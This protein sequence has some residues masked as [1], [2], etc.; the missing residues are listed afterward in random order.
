M[1]RKEEDFSLDDSRDIYEV[2]IDVISVLI[3]CI[4]ILPSA[5]TTDFVVCYA[6]SLNLSPTFG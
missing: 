6:L 4:R 1:S 3:G 5:I 2:L